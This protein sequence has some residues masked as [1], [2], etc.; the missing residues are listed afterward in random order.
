MSNP[1]L[2]MIILAGG[3]ASG[4]LSQQGG[5]AWKGL[6]DPGGGPLVARVVS[7]ALESRLVK[8]IVVAGPPD[9]HSAA[10]GDVLAASAGP[11]PLDTALL[12]LEM[13]G[14]ADRV[15]LCGVDSALLTG[16]AIDDFVTRTP[17]D[18]DLAMPVVH[19]ADFEQAFPGSRRPYVRLKSGEVTAGSQF[20]IGRRLLHE[21]RDLFLRFVRFRKSQPAMALALGP[22]F[23][24]RL[25]TGRLDIPELEGRARQLT[26]ASCRAV[27]GC[28]ASLAFDVDS[29]SDL[30]YLRQRIA[31]AGEAGRQP[32]AA[33]PGAWTGSGPIRPGR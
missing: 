16:P 17:G 2:A 29:W 25:L 32:D 12:G 24:W 21:Q 20:L 31:A 11:T 28:D 7:A 3:R 5:A 23:L 26:R 18:A 19:R 33:D 4:R 8:R 6:L 22:A 9:L 13:A 1:E 10:S 27:H 30:E 14:D 15:L